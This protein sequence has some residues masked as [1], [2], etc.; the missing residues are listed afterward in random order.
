MGLKSLDSH[1]AVLNL[2]R[3]NMYVNESPLMTFMSDIMLIQKNDLKIKYEFFKMV[4]Q[5]I[6]Y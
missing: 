2:P 5:N 3:I 1:G 6:I 4:I